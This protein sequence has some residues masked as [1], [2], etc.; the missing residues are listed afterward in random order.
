M[1]NYNHILQLTGDPGM[2]FNGQAIYG[3]IASAH[4]TCNA[5]II[6]SFDV[7]TYLFTTQYTYSTYY[8]ECNYILSSDYFVTPG[9]SED[10]ITATLDIRTLIVVMSVNF[11]YLPYNT[12]ESVYSGEK[13]ING[14]TYVVHEK[15]DTR[16]PGMTP[17]VCYHEI[18]QNYEFSYYYDFI[19][20]AEMNETRSCVYYL[21]TYYG[22]DLYGIPILNPAGSVD[23]YCGW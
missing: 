2:V 14:I 15:F 8:K 21:N 9:S 23:P 19:P 20:T 3:S 11:N 7:N 12:L 10:I 16:Y 6:S 17:I 5:N 13:V 18:P 1:N 4:G 22:G